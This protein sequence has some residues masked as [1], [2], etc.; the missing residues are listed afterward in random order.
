MRMIRQLFVG[1]V[2]TATMVG[3]LRADPIADADCSIPQHAQRII[4]HCASLKLQ[5]MDKQLAGLYQELLAA[6][7]DQLD[8]AR[9][10]AAE[11]AWLHYRE[12]QCAFEAPSGRQ[13]SLSS[14]MYTS[15]A[16][17]LTEMRINQLRRY[18]ECRVR[19]EPDACRH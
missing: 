9:L 13:G 5:E 7:P 4:N 11:N 1:A 8:R 2:A 14:L 6:M 3:C 10:Q 12:A 16:R 19:Q 18:L 15:C 17:D